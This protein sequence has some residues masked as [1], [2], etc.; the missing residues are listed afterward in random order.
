MNFNR[1]IVV[2]TFLT[3]AL[4]LSHLFYV[5]AFAQQQQTQ[6][7][8]EDELSDYLLA[9]GFVVK[10][11]SYVKGLKDDGNTTLVILAEPLTD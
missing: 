11:F 2:I 10:V 1:N 5:T 4:V 3:S 8:Y 6:E 9:R 7:L